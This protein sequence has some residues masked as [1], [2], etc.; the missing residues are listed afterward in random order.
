MGRLQ[1]GDSMLQA[2]QLYDGYTYNFTAGQQLRF[3]AVS[4]EFDP[5]IVVRTPSGRELSNDD[6]S[7][8]DHTAGIDLSVPETGTYSVT[9]T[10]YSPRSDAK[11]A[12]TAA[13]LPH[14]AFFHS[15]FHCRSIHIGS[16][17]RR[18]PTEAPGVP[19][20]SFFS[21]GSFAS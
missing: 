15:T 13:G 7:D 16:S 3:R 6:L 19:H 20:R 4:S 8:T 5:Y 2:G 9:V 14:V 11:R 12:V 18:A 21:P 1:Q 10:S 17:N